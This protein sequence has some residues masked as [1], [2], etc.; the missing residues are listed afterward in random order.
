[1]QILCYRWD[2]YNQYDVEQAF[3]S[4]GF[5]LTI[6]SKQ[7][8]HI[9]EDSA[10]TEEVISLLQ[11][12]SYAF[13]FS[14]NYFPVLARAC[15]ETDTLYVCWNCDSPLLSMY[16][17]SVFYDTNVIF[18]F[19]YANYKEFHELGVPH[20]YHLP[21]GVPVK[22]LESVLSVKQDNTYPVSFVGSLYEQNSYDRIVMSLPDYLCGYFESAMH[23]QTMVSGGNLLEKLL[24]DDICEQIE[25]MTTY[26]TSEDSFATVRTLFAT[27]VL[28]FKT[29]NIERISRLNALSQNMLTWENSKD[30]QIHLFTG[31][32]TEMLP[33]VIT[34]PPVD[35]LTQMPLVFA[36]SKINLNM[37]IPNIKTGIPLRAWDIMACHGFLLTNYQTEF[38]SHFRAGVHMDFFEDTE[39][40]L[41]KAAFYLSHDSLR[42]SIAAKGTEL[43]QKEHTLEQ[44]VQ[45]MVQVIQHL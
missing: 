2:A 18:T 6:L 45:K 13:L 34:H 44:R 11:N 31:S 43:V 42:E 26:H 41:D 14:I 32:Q 35:Y 5:S 27:T 7:I 17:T 29:A 38:D 28:G 3:Q 9:E 19:D 15:H 33:L 21:L 8:E 25:E 1:M 16:H 30:N 39:E 22:R 4:L 23:A 24:T 37:T 20:I 10:Y 12:G 40:L 36:N